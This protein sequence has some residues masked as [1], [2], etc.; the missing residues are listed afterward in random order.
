MDRKKAVQRLLEFKT[1]ETVKLAENLNET[2][3]KA[4]SGLLERMFTLPLVIRQVS[5]EALFLIATTVWRILCVKK[6]DA[7]IDWYITYIYAV[8]AV[9]GAY[10]IRIRALSSISNENTYNPTWSEIAD[11]L[12]VGCCASALDISI[13]HG[14]L[15]SCVIFKLLCSTFCSECS[16]RVGAHP[17]AIKVIESF[18]LYKI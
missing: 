11:H 13:T 8:G 3:R 15:A 9:F 12:K 2:Q 4:I 14:D 17:D 6:G 7:M 1:R 5:C 16:I 18:A 10:S